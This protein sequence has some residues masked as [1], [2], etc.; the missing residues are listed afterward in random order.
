[1]VGRFAGLKQACDYIRIVPLTVAL[2]AT[3]AKLMRFSA[4]IHGLGH[5]HG[6]IN[7]SRIRT[8]DCREVMMHN[9]IATKAVLLIVNQNPP[10]W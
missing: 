5:T 8:K 1:M 6:T 10:Q 4:W 2:H 3:K 7:K 9:N